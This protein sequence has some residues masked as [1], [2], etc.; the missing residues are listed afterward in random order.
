M[1]SGSPSSEWL[2]SATLVPSA[3][4][5]ALATMVR[6]L[7]SPTLKVPPIVQRPAAYVLPV[8]ASD[9]CTATEAGIVS[10]TRTPVALS[11]PSLVSVIV[12]VT[13]WFL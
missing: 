4:V 9:D 3:L 2:T 11:G 13:F 10:V 7:V 12:Y 5:T 8:P 1:E 6:V